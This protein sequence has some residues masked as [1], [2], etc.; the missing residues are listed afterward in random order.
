MPIQQGSIVWVTMTDG[1]G[2]T[3]RRPAVVLT[4]ND[5]ILLDGPVVVAAITTAYGE[6][7]PHNLVELPWSSQ[8]I[9]RTGLR[10][11]SAAVCNWLVDAAISDLEDTGHFVPTKY[12]IE[13]LKRLPPAS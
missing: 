7:P 3:K 11:R 4:A 8:G 1:R 9:A 2:F 6:P 12:L 13:I 5:E 10:R